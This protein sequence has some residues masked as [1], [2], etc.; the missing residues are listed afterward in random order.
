M[1]HARREHLPLPAILFFLGNIGMAL[2]DPDAL[3]ITIDIIN[4]IR[5]PNRGGDDRIDFLVYHR[6]GAITRYH[7]GSKSSQHAIPHTI[8][9]GSRAYSRA[10]AFDQGV[11]AALHV[12]P[13]GLEGTTSLLQSTT[14]RSYHGCS[15]LWTPSHLSAP[16][17]ARSPPPLRSHQRSLVS[18]QAT[19]TGPARDSHGGSSSQDAHL[20]SDQCFAT[21]SFAWPAGFSTTG[22]ST[23]KFPRERRRDRCGSPAA[24]YA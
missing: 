2:G 21:A 10:I 4:G 11:R 6:S 19:Q 24:A 18:R 20:R 16:W 23:W 15:L 5:D 8:P 12:R 1:A 3:Q 17:T 9:H 7:P 13:P 22:P 14:A